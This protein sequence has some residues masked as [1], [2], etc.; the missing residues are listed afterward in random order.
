MYS[1]NS[2]TTSA[3]PLNCELGRDLP[4]R[5]TLG[6]D[7]FPMLKAIHF[8]RSYGSSGFRARC[9]ME[10]G[11]FQAEILIVHGL[12]RTERLVWHDFGAHGYP[13]VFFLGVGGFWDFKFWLIR[14]IGQLKQELRSVKIQLSKEARRYPNGHTFGTISGV[15]YKVGLL[16]ICLSRYRRL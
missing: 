8:Y 11:C 4:K 15:R 1:M 5:G 16:R 7:T 9:E 13:S 3:I 12:T 14:F 6:G 10:Y 2:F